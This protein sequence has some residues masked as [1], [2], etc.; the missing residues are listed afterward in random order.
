MGLKHHPRVVTNG[1]FLYYDPANLR[2]YVGSGVTI[3]NLF[4][5]YGATFVNGPTFSSSNSGYI[6][7][8]GSN[9]YAQLTLPALTS[10]SFSF[11]I[12]NHTIPNLTEKQL[13]ST[14]GDPT[15]LSMVFTYYNIWNGTSNFSTSSVAQSTWSNVV[16]TNNGFSSSAIYIDG[17]LD[18]PFNS[19]NQIYSGA[20]Q[21]MAI[22]GTSRNTQAFIGSVMGYNRSLSAA[23]VLQNYNATK[24]R[25]G[26]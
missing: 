4:A 3:N 15:G 18:A 19:G 13:L 1:L 22:N 26:K 2:S 11:W 7:F 17:R 21:L 5:G 16:F 20:A 10:W 9:D 25:Y 12:Y 14:N 8:D 6:S 24:K 23:E